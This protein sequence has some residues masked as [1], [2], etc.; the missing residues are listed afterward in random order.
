MYRQNYGSMAYAVCSIYRGVFGISMLYMYFRVTV[1][2]IHGLGSSVT[3]NPKR[4]RVFFRRCGHTWFFRRCGQALFQFDLML[5]LQC[6]LVC[7]KLLGKSNFWA[8]SCVASSYETIGESSIS[9]VSFL[10]QAIGEVPLWESFFV[11][12]SWESCICSVFYATSF[13]EIVGITSFLAAIHW[14]ILIC[15]FFFCSKL[16]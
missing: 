14:G 1:P 15:G 2:T 6:F 11:T 5:H 10:H 13:W 4:R 8:S 16:L 12:G 7:S 3:P 9:R